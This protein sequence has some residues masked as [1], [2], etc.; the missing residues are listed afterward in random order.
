MD[1]SWLIQAPYLLAPESETTPGDPLIDRRM[2]LAGT[3]AMLLAARRSRP[4][5]SRRSWA[6]RRRNRSFSTCAT[7][8]AI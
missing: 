6:S 2:F 8:K 3:G 4:R 7:A 1:P 5:R